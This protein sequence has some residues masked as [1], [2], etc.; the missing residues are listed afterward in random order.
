[1]KEEYF[2]K[3]FTEIREGERYVEE[4]PPPEWMSVEIKYKEVDISND[5]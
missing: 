5:G 3:S 2:P 1:M 4:K